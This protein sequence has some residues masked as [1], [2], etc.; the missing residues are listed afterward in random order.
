MEKAFGDK[1][2]IIFNKD[3]GVTGNLNVTVSKKGSKEGT[4]IHSKKK[5]DGLITE[6]NKDSFIEKVRKAMN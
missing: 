1:V 6:D 3:P 2:F 4:T 5:G